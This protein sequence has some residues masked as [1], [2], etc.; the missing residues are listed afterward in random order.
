MSV[1]IKPRE[2]RRILGI[3]LTILAYIGF[4]T[5]DTC[6]KWLTLSGMPTMQVVFIRYAAQFII[7]LAIFLPQHG[8]GLVR[9]NRLGLEILRALALL[10]STISN[11]LAVIWLPLTI[12][13][14][15]MFTQP[16]ILCALSI[17]FLGERVGWRR[18]VAIL[19]GFAGV[20]IIVQPGTDAFHPAAALSILSATF[21]AIYLILTRKLAGVDATGTQHFYTGLV[22]TIAIAPF[23]FGAWVW[24]V[25]TIGWIALGLIGV[26]A[27]LGHQAITVAHRFAPATVLAPFSY[28]QII[29]MSAS[30]WLIFSQPPT[31][32]LFVGAP[33]VIGSG[34]YIWLRERQLGKTPTVADEGV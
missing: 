34:L 14:A 28:F 33:I 25:D 24:P 9:S 20:L 19:V 12:T 27:V 29:W 31:M 3:I 10:A 8:T 22:A 5:I 1:E 21:G 32:W 18:L 11:F 7:V 6:A 23:A 15:I 16:L 30:S 2:D 4:T 13:S 17:P 26:A